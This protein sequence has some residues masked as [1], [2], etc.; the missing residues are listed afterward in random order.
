MSDVGELRRDKGTGSEPRWLAESKRWQARYVTPDG[1]RRSVYCSA[2]GPAG[3]KACARL[4]DEQIAAA[5]AGVDPSLQPLGE[6]LARYLARRTNLTDATRK[7]YGTLIRLHV[8]GSTAT[9]QRGKG[10]R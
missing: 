8:E 1:K 9:D 7:R 4:R 6:Y 2:P 3:K 10:V 5:A